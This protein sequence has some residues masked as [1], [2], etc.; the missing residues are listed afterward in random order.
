MCTCVCVCVCV[1]VTQVVELD[2]FSVTSTTRYPAPILSMGIAPDCGTLAVGCADGTLI[3]RKHDRP[4]TVTSGI[5][6]KPQKK[7][8]YKPKLTAENYRWGVV[9]TRARAH[10]HTYA[11]IYI[12]RHL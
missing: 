3:T 8:H 1:C 5:S 10:R 2:S 9:H 11:H 7:V 12:D 4:R 6:A